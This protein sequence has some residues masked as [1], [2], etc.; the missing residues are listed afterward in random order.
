MGLF[1]SHSKR[2]ESQ[3]RQLFEGAYGHSDQSAQMLLRTSDMYP[4][5]LSSNFERFFGVPA[6]R[7]RE[8]VETLYRFIPDEGRALVKNAIAGWAGTEPLNVATW[9]EVPSNPPASKYFSI[10]LSPAH[11]GSYILVVVSNITE[12]HRAVEEAR[13]K[14]D[15][16]LRLMRERTDFLSQMSHEIRTPLNGIKGLISMAKDH[17]SEDA[18]LLDDLTRADELSDYLLSLV[19]DVLDVSRLNSGRVEL[20]SLPFDVR[21]LANNLE[22]MFANQA[23]DKGIAFS[24]DYSDCEHVFLLGDQLRLNQVVVNFLSNAIKFT[25]EG[26]SVEV[27]F[28]EMY[29]NDGVANFMIRVRDTGKGMDPR[30]VGR[31]FK[32]FE[33]ED[34]TISRKYGGTG[35]GMAIADGLV[36]LM[37]GEIV[38]DTEPGRGSDFAVYLPLK[39][40]SS[41]QASRLADAGETLETHK[42]GMNG[43]ELYDM[44]DRRFLM[45]EDNDLNA[46]IAIQ[47]LQS[48]NAVIDVANDGPVVVDMF[49]ESEPFSYDAILMDIQMPTFNGWEATKRIRALDRPDAQSIPIIALS[50]NNY[51]E[52]AIASREA[53]LDGHTGKPINI[54]ELKEQ[55]AQAV[56]RSGYRKVK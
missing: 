43:A 33:Q 35:L 5:Y 34:R 41:A 37:G 14:R 52:D 1:G 8:D 56:A 32:P 49:A 40:A 39:L 9:Y 28:R 22:T 45:A 10:D 31:I 46:L 7:M 38:V 55:L 36:S 11:Q 13:Q 4:V 53:G 6:E 25:D 12:G 20:E 27:A 24:V 50:A 29:A 3:A 44:A 21:L 42:A 54:N 15:D 16:A 17:R 51:V 2:E 48:E 26:G 30:F 19:N 23:K 18:L 47:I